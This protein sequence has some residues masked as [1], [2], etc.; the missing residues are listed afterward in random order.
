MFSAGCCF[1][2]SF[3][4]DMYYSLLKISGNMMKVFYYAMKRVCL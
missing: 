4:C 2:N 1:L 3:Y